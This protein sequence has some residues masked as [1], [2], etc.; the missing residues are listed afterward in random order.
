MKNFRDL[1]IPEA[2]LDNLLKKGIQTASEIQKKA[3]PLLLEHSG[4]FV[5]QSA[6]GTGKTYSFGI[7]L[8]SRINLDSSKTQA[9]VLVPT[10][11]LAEQVGRELSELGLGLQNLKILSI[12]GGISLKAQSKA[13]A[14]GAQII[15]ATAG[16]MVDLI[17]RKAIALSALKYVIFDEADQM[18]LSGF[19]NDIDYILGR[20]SRNY[21]SWLFSA[22][23]PDSIHKVIKKYLKNNLIQIKLNKAQDNNLNIKHEVIIVPAIDK[24]NTLLHFLTTLSPKRGIIF[25]RTKSAVQKLYKNL[26]AHKIS[27]AALHGDLPQGL[28]N[29]MMDQ[30]R[31]GHIDILIATDV[32]SR[33][34]DIVDTAFV[35]Q[36]QLA[37]TTE[38]YVHRTGR[39]SRTGN[40]GLSI[41][42]IF[43]EEE[44]KL[45]KIT[46]QLEIKLDFLKLPN[47]QDLM[48]NKAIL[49][50]RKIAKEKPL[51]GLVDENSKA[52]FKKQLQ[53]LS[54]DELLE[55]LL[56]D[57][58]RRQ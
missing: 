34:L 36:Y 56:A 50:A 10:R 26:S 15:V 30:Y 2:I 31:N 55:K 8:L 44:E 25:C 42:F 48:L 54:K 9:I 28:R 57:Y 17:E 5:G 19:G 22:T 49:W 47:Y 37:D 29:K 51:H 35:I 4:D 12:Y 16:R 3:I 1:Q 58:L 38:A 46:S 23:M 39:T 43:P 20:S 6:T 40:Q 52:L 21:S 7:P 33:G 27:T 32:A 41:S 13:L 24:L 14:H 11:E 45:L 18:L 53:Q